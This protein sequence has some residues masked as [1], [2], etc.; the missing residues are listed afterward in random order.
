MHMHCSAVRIPTHLHLEIASQLSA[1]SASAKQGM[2][3]ASHGQVV[4]SRNLLEGNRW[5][6]SM[7]TPRAL[8]S[9]WAH[10]SQALLLILPQLP[11]QQ[12]SGLVIQRLPRLIHGRQLSQHVA[13][14]HKDAL[15][16]LGS[17]VQQ[18]G[19]GAPLA[20]VLPPSQCAAP[21]HTRRQI[22]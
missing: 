16:L 20:L 14:G 4:Q 12:G 19:Q 15:L 13:A 10:P 1:R 5:R 3:L 2:H 11:L 6:S 22:R 8:Q 17:E 21:A 7:Q 18:A 9:R